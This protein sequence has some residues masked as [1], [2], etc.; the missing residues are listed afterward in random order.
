MVESR[1]LR[2]LSEAGIR[3]WYAPDNIARGAVWPAEIRKGL[4]QCD[5]MLVVVSQNAS[6]SDWVRLEIDLAMGLGH[7]QGRIIPVQLDDTPLRRVNEFLVSMQA[8]DIRKT[9]DLVTAIAQLISARR[10]ADSVS[11]GGS[12][13]R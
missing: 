7:M 8:V 10:A 5:W 1:L 9:P 6:T 4:S 13:G 11:Q 2:P 12:P 3:T